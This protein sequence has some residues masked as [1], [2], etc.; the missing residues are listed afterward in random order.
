MGKKGNYAYA[1]NGQISVDEKAQIIVGQ[2]VSQNANDK[3]EVEPALEQIQETMGELPEK[4]SQ[5]N[6]YLSGANLEKL[7]D[8]GVDAYVATGR[9]DRKDIRPVEDCN[10]EIKKP[11]F[12]CDSERDCFTCPGGQT[13]DLKSKGE[14]GKRVYQAQRE[15]CGQC[16]YRERCCKSEKGEPRTITTDDKEPLRQQMI[17]KMEQDSSKDVY[18]KRKVIV[19]PSLRSNKEQWLS[20]IPL[21]RLQKSKRRILTLSA[22][23]QLQEDSRSTCEG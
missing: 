6:G 13:L 17:D 20:R 1:Y 8:A 22:R 18:K 15:A 16:S 21:A 12:A 5:D 3:K 9:E 23:P 14:D 7:N 19:E 4:M 11:D 2:H 10:R